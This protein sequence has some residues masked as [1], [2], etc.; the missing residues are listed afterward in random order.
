MAE[1]WGGQRQRSGSLAAFNPC[2][3]AIINQLLEVATDYR[4]L[5]QFISHM[6]PVET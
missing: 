2:E 3:V 1:S 5:S 4:V 6:F